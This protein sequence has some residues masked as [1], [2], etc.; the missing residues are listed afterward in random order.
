MAD[1]VEEVLKVVPK[2]PLHVANYPTGL[3]NKVADFKK[4]VLLQKHESAEARVVGIVGLGGVGKT[5]LAKEFFNSER[6]KYRRSSFL[7]D[8]REK[9]HGGSLD[10]LQGQL[11]KDLNQ[12]DL[13]INNTAKGISLIKR[14]LSGSNA[15]MV[16]DDV[17]HID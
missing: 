17:D 3:A 9:H 8:V 16:V 1:V 14:H 15:L 2:L 5:T 4:K 6:T 12:L 11:I 10:T 7:S 13:Q